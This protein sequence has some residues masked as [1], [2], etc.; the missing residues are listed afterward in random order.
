MESRKKV[1]VEEHCAHPSLARMIL[2]CYQEGN[3]GSIVWFSSL[4]RTGHKEGAGKK[5][6]EQ[7]KIQ[8]QR[9]TQ[10]LHVVSAQWRCQLM[11]SAPWR[12]QLTVSAQRRC[13][14]MVHA[15]RRCW[16]MVR[17]QQRLCILGFICS[18]FSLSLTA[19]RLSRKLCLW[20]VKGHQMC[21]SSLQRFSTLSP[22]HN[23]ACCWL[24]LHMAVTQCML[25]K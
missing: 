19:L 16:L 18:N 11:V 2:D 10:S 4:K 17:A 25:V 1:N 23:L 20:V 21:G 7:S 3:S 6:P 14:L 9:L 22:W 24:A 13:W 8:E 12:C 5:P 15:Q